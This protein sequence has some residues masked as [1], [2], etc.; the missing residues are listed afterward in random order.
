M[1]GGQL[2]LEEKPAS[3]RKTRLQEYLIVFGVS[4]SLHKKQTGKK[5]LKRKVE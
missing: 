1:D 4:L 2:P 5:A 3:W